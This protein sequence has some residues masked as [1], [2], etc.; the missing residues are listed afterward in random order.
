[1]VENE[2]WADEIGK[3]AYESIAEMVE[4]LDGDDE[5][6]ALETIQEDPLSVQVRSDW[7]TPGEE[8]VKPSEY[9]ILLS[10]GGPASRIL[11]DLDEYGQPTR[12]RLEVQDWFKP[13]TEYFDVDH[14][15]LLRY[16]QCFYF[17]D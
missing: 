2:N 3:S 1:M 15:I 9:E 6:S 13:W 5:E 11:G 17:G 4:A 10:T 7:Y 16:A 8:D 14:K 12:A